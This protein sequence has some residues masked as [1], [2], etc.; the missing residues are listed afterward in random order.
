MPEKEMNDLQERGSFLFPCPLYT[1][2]EEG[3]AQIRDGTFHLK[4]SGSKM[5]PHISNDPVKQ[6][7]PSQMCPA[8]FWVLVNFRYSQVDNKNSH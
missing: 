4:R 2:L 1:L 6:K 3:V 8:N 7:S 5:C